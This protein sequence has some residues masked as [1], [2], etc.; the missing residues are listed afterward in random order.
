MR[1]GSETSSTPD[2]SPGYEEDDDDLGDFNFFR[3]G[4]NKYEAAHDENL[5]KKSG[6]RTF[7]EALSPTTNE[8]KGYNPR[9]SLSNEKSS[10]EEEK[11]I[12]SLPLPE[13]V[14]TEILRRDEGMRQ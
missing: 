12:R 10:S 1:G 8:T 11:D 14:R 13:S 3:K 4:L 6:K 7:F 2:F 9:F 5:L